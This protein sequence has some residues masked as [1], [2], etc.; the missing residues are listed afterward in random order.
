MAEIVLTRI[1]DK[2]LHGQV[3]RTWLKYVG[4]N[5]II[6]ADDKV[7]KDEE[8]IKILDIAT[9]LGVKSYFLSIADTIEKINHLE[10]DK[11]IILLLENTKQ[12]LE[13][14]D[15]GLSIDKLNI[16]NLSKRAGTKEVT[17]TIYLKDEEIKDLEK[18]K[19]KGID[20]TIQA[21]PDDKFLTLEDIK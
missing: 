12:A 16:G 5:T 2:L 3:S 21:L 11:K 19:E 13:I 7:A 15:K 9:P 20:V 18:I 6:V 4:A 14:L 10:N 1:D 17:P 8:K